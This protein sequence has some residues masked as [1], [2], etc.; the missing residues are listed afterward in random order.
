MMCRQ[1]AARP[2]STSI[3]SLP[4][5]ATINFAYSLMSELLVDAERFFAMSVQ[6]VRRVAFRSDVDRTLVAVWHLWSLLGLYEIYFSHGAFV[7]FY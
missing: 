1:Y 5:Y 2:P 7:V 3:N 4:K 6:R